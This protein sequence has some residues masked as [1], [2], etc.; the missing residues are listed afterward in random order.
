MFMAVRN[1]VREASQNRHTLFHRHVV[2][3]HT[4]FVQKRPEG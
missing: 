2:L 4:G 1:E 3:H